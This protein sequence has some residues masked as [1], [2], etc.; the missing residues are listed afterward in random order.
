MS[1]RENAPT[2]SPLLQGRY[3]LLSEGS[4]HDLGTA[5]AAHDVQRDQPVLLLLLSRRFPAGVETLNRL[6]EI[7]QGLIGLAQPGLI[8]FEHSGLLDEQLYVIRAHAEAHTLADLLARAG[9][10]EIATAVEIAIRVCETLAPAHRAGLV[11]GSLSTH[12]VLVEESTTTTGAPDPA[13]ALADFGLLP[14]LRPTTA[15]RGQPWGR[16]PYLSPE[17]A[18]GEPLQ[19]ASDVY[20]I[21]SLIYEMLTG[22]PP[23]R[24]SDETILVTQ[25]LRQEPPSLQVLVPDVSPALA[26]MVHATLAKE[27]AA[28]YRN[29]G[30]LAHVLRTQIRPQVASPDPVP[31]PVP[32]QQ[33]PAPPHLVVPPPPADAWA[34]GEIYDLEG[35]EY[36]IDEPAGADWLM[37]GL[38]VLALIAVLGLIPLWQTV[39]RRYA[40]PPPAPASSLH[41]LEDHQ[42]IVPESKKLRLCAPEL[43]PHPQANNR[44]ELDDLAIVWYNDLSLRLL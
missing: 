18:A 31:Q 12:S 13:V 2:T 16:I 29:A 44:P 37:I 14:A 27:P 23:F 39:Y 19:P 32:P 6:D 20:V 15:P 30:Q 25:H 11:H 40:A 26:Q 7:Q 41:H 17:Q 22:R 5:F 1:Q 43:S 24:A 38:A 3:R 8:P 35:S 42:E 21:G 9:R 34:S 4:P 36:W 28:R 33:P 10:L